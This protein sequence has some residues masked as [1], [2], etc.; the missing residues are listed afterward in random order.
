MSDTDIQKAQYGRDAEYRALGAA[1]DFSQLYDLGDFNA[2]LAQANFQRG[3]PQAALSPL[4]GWGDSWLGEQALNMQSR[5]N[6]LASSFTVEDIL[7][8]LIPAGGQLGSAA[9]MAGA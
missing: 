6:D 9:I 3:A 7:G 8:M 5:A 1:G 4:E 2:R